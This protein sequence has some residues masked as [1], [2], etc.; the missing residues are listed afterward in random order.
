MPQATVSTFDESALA[1][2]VLLDDGAALSFD[3]EAFAYSGL[4]LL[5]VGQRLQVDVG[6]DGH[7]RRLSLITM[8]WQ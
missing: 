3:A 1:G 6:S 5:R 4:R 2:T 8:P 7:I